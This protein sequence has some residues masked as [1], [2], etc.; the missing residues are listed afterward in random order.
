MKPLLLALLALTLTAAPARADHEA[1]HLVQTGPDVY[2]EVCPAEGAAVQRS[3]ETRETPLRRWGFYLGGGAAVGTM[4]SAETELHYGGALALA[5]GL[6]TVRLD[7]RLQ[8]IGRA[9]EALRVTG[10]TGVAFLVYD[11]RLAPYFGA[12]IGLEHQAL[13]HQD[14]MT[15]QLLDVETT[16]FVGYASVGVEALRTTTHRILVEGRAYLPAFETG[17]GR[18][19]RWTPSVQGMVSFLW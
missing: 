10:D 17:Y 6:G 14:P 16:G 12:G 7:G 4:F 2:Q 15:G 19:E 9:G 5:I 13:E 11:G 1:C 8:I 18:V 3:V